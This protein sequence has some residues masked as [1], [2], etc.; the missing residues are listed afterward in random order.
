MSRSRAAM[1]SKNFP[2]VMELWD[3]SHGDRRVGANGWAAIAMSSGVVDV[4][5]IKDRH[6][7][8]VR[9]R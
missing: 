9:L 4:P 6:D 1:N 7:R 5:T 8:C 3:G 2:N